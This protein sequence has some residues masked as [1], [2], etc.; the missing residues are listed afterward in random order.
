[1]KVL[2]LCSGNSCRSQMAQG[3]LQ[4]FDLS[5]EV[6]SAGTKPAKDVNEYAIKVMAEIGIDIS[7]NK[8]KSVNSYLG[9]NWDFVITVCGSANEFCPIFYG[10]VKNRIHIGFDDPSLITGSNEHILN[11]F[12]HTRDRIKQRL[13]KFYEEN[14]KSN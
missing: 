1:M 13:F 11:E 3:L 6:H 7:K 8:P 10:K 12:R 4:S 14:L 2:I 5:L 9:E